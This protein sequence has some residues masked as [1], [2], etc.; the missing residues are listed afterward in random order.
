MNLVE[1]T[2][3]ETDGSHGVTF[4]SFRLGIPAEVLDRRPA[5]RGYEGRSVILG[6]RPED[7]EDASLVA[8]APA[9][10]RIGARVLLR[11]ALGA[12]VVVHLKI[13][14][15]EV[16]TD[17]VKELADDVGVEALQAV[18]QRAEAGESTFL[19]R[20]NPRTEAQTDRLVELVVDVTRLHYFDPESGLAIYDGSG[21]AS[22]AAPV[23]S[24]AQ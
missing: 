14:A 21:P 22:D 7:L 3:T 11:E 15:P 6:L 2:L 4:G 5:L 16:L 18:E 10:R 12:D 17:D 1:A 13:D 8:E 19:A 24:A 23:A 20:L 9:D